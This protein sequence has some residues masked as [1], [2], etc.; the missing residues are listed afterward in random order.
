MISVNTS[1]L[2]EGISEMLI[3]E[4]LELIS[5]PNPT[6]STSYIYLKNNYSKKVLVTIYNTIGRV[7]S[8][9]N[10]EVI[11]NKIQI[12]L[13]NQPIGMY[14]INVFGNSSATVKII[15]Q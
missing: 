13:L 11:D 6:I 1:K 15:K 4:K 12:D 9:N 10:M 3:N 2:C 14:H 7:I 8:S 5:S